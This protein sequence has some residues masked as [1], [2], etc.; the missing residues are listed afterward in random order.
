[1]ARIVGKA[2]LADIEHRKM[3]ILLRIGTKI[4]GV[5]LVPA[6]RQSIKILH[7]RDL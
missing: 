1:M 6:D 5:D 2:K 4:P 3:C 7:T